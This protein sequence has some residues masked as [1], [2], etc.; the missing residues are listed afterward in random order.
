MK[1]VAPLIAEPATLLG[2]ELHK[3]LPAG[4][5]MGRPTM[6]V[7]APPGIKEEELSTTEESVVVYHVT[8]STKHRS[9][10]IMGGQGSTIYLSA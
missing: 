3:Q 2:T 9:R 8:P 1:G 7:T 10:F 6:V 4:A 5:L